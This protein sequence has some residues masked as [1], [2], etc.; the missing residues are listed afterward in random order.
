MNILF[1][2]NSEIVATCDGIHR[3]TSTLSQYF[4]IKHEYKCFLAYLAHNKAEPKTEFEEKFQVDKSNIYEQFSDFLTR[5]KIDIVICQH[6]VGT[7]KIFE[8]MK[9]AVNKTQN[10]K[11]VYCFHLAPDYYFVHP[12]LNAEI[13]R[14]FD[15]F[16]NF[17]KIVVGLLP[18][19]L[20]NILVSKEIQKE[21]AIYNDYFD[22]IVLLSKRYIQDYNKLSNIPAWK[23]KDVVAIPNILTFNE[24][25][26]EKD[27]ESKENIV[28]IV[29]RLSERL[30]RISQSLKIWKKVQQ[31]TDIKD[32]R[33]I[34]LGIGDDEKYYKKL[35]KKLDIKKVY[36]EG[37]QNPIEYY[38]KASVYMMT[39][40]SEGWGLTLTEAQQMG[41]V[42]IVF[43]SFGAVHD[44]IEDKYNGLIIPNNDIE[45]YA[46]KLAWLMQHDE[47]CQTMACNAVESSKKFHLSEIGKQW[48]KLLE[49]TL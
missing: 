17:R 49:D 6:V 19:L 48:V 9:L 36:F 16:K 26:S 34:I 11:F 43:D 7:R 30:K 13:F 12:N 3:I 37:R 14:F 8:Q 27:I 40:A 42:P 18:K 38:K 24:K 20:Y 31:R 21:L 28:L 1:V 23:Q 33:L 5:N 22:K 25:I 32:W 39:S 45:R 47:E 44:I 46:D 29:A 35:V 41:V 2:T 10:C 15:T 4:T